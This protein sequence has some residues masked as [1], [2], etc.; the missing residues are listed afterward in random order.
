MR[1]I[2][3]LLLLCAI[4]FTNAQQQSFQSWKIAA[5]NDKRMLPEYG[6]QTKSTEEIASDNRFINA[7]LQAGT[8][9]S[10]GAYEMIR[11]GFDYLYKGD[12]KT[13][14]Y[15]FNQAFLLNPN[16]SGIYWGYG[17]IYSA[18]GEYHLAR[19]QYTKGLQ[20]EP[21]SAAI[22]TDFGTTYLGEYYANVS[23]N[24][25]KAAEK[26]EMA[27]EKFLASFAIDSEYIHTAYK[28]SIV[29]LYIGDCSNAKKYL[30]K[31]REL[32]GQPITKSYLSDFNLR[33]ANCSRVK[34]GQFEINSKEIGKTTIKRSKKFQ[35]EEN[36]QMNYKLKLK[37]D[38][39]DDCT[40]TLQ[41]I[42]NYDNKRELPKELLTCQ[43]LEVNED[44]Y[45]Q[46]STVGNNQKPLTSEIS[47]IH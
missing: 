42:S 22:L 1:Y 6:N 11:L 44:S 34:I 21:R 26:L 4:S 43:I 39:L 36:K 38:W 2:T 12:L 28:L 33:C 17:A 3:I 41:P 13:A 9:K 40:Y 18:F 46:V 35:I 15:R 47:I 25:N 32:G 23:Q 14:M 27:K 20:L 31:T 29:Y 37:V 30:N 5:E 10:E 24:Q 19:E 7:L 45:I 8:S 16:N